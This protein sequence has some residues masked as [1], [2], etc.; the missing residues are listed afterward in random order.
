[1]CEG[2][3]LVHGAP[4]GVGLICGSG[5]GAD[6]LHSLDGDGFLCGC[7]SLRW[8]IADAFSFGCGG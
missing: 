3:N 5:I 7:G 4:L 8:S 2:A 1:M 6:W